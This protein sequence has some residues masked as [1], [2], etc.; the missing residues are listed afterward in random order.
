MARIKLLFIY[1]LN[2]VF[3]L[4]FIFLHGCK[5]FSSI[6]YRNS[7]IEDSFSKDCSDTKNS[8][9]MRDRQVLF[10]KTG[11]KSCTDLYSFLSNVKNLNLDNT[12][13]YS[14]ELLRPALSMTSLSA[15]NNNI[16]DLVGLR[17]LKSLKELNLENN[18]IRRIDDLSALHNLEQLYLSHNKID[19]VKALSQLPNLII[20]TLNYNQ[21]SDFSP[22]FE[23]ESLLAIETNG[24]PVPAT[25]CSQDIKTR[26]F[27]KVCGSIKNR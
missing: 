26:I 17:E 21:I 25:Q 23:A 15:R 18:H 4:N 1:A 7:S 27:K 13:F 10:S 2:R 14:T 19:S 6:S 5:S 11:Q 12:G 16:Q 9:L 22:M 8:K 24:N 20:L 3:I